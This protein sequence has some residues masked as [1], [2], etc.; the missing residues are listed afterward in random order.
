M[1][2]ERWDYAYIKKAKTKIDSVEELRQAMDTLKLSLNDVKIYARPDFGAM[3]RVLCF[4]R[5]LSKK[6]QLIVDLVMGE[7]IDYDS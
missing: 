7:F 2:Q 3:M 5:P 4:S 1:E 6:E